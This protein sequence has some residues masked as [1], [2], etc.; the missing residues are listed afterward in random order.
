MIK[1][2]LWPDLDQKLVNA[3]Y[4]GQKSVLLHYLPFFAEENFDQAKKFKVAITDLQKVQCTHSFLF[5]CTEILFLKQNCALKE[6]GDYKLSTWSKCLT[7]KE[8]KDISTG[9]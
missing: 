3:L 4:Y 7:F 5:K 6:D 9:K 1:C 2:I 8:K